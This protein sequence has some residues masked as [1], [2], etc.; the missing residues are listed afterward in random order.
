MRKLAA[1][2]VLAL[3]LVTL[4][5]VA[6]A[7][8]AWQV[9]AHPSATTIKLGGK[10]VFKGVVRPGAAAAG[11]KV[12]LQEK[13]AANKPWKTK[14]TD[15]VGSSGHYQVS[16]KPDHATI[17]SYRVVMA[18]SGH[19]VTGISKVVE[20]EVY[21]WTNLT[22]T[23]TPVNDFS[24][25]VDA[26]I[27]MNGTTYQHS[28]WSRYAAMS[29]H[30]EYNVDHLCTA[31]RA[32]YG[33]SDESESGAQA[34]VT[35]LSDGATV[36]TGGFSVGQTQTEKVLLD[37]PLKLRFESTSLAAGLNGFGAVGTPQVL[38]TKTP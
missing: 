31:L 28:I 2:G 21:A 4:P 11:Q 14:A 26:A 13:Y 38:C 18:A 29:N 16:D 32:T 37:S 12:Q 17:R 20:V 33:L 10:V 24:F 1:A 35:A 9:T 7:G 22:S 15:K 8:S 19:R 3:G 5:G 25:S 34:Q 30:V 6:Q 27:K 23:F 36:F